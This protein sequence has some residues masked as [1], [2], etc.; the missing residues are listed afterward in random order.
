MVSEVAV[1]QHVEQTA[2][3]AK[4]AK[5]QGFRQPPA[6]TSD[7]TAGVDIR[8]VRARPGDGSTTASSASETVALRNDK[9]R[10]RASTMV[11]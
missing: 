9:T 7:Q 8:V 11:F 2:L 4:N 3:P 6:T 10:I 1:C 5:S